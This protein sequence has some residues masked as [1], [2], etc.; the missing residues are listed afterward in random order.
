[1]KQIKIAAPL[2]MDTILKLKIGDQVLITGTIYTARDA[3]HKRIIELINNEE[4]LPFDLSGQI[5]YYVGPTPAKPN[6]IIGSAGPTTST[7]MDDYTPTLLK[8]GLKG[9]IGKGLR[10][11]TV[12]NAIAKH[13]AVYFA[14]VGGAG[15]VISK[16]I[17][18][19]EIIA[20]KELDT[21]AV[22]KLT[23]KDLPVIVVNDCYG[24]DLYVVGKEKF[25][26]KI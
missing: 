24:G 20:F 4:D 3:A 10:S 22:R 13:Q 9:M 19:S 16:A 23:V 18:T 1:M 15:A 12:K 11:Q 17:I 14:A 7:R 6:K 8:L 2:D 5:I 25:S 26:D 21:E